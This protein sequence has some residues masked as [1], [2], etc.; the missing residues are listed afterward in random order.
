MLGLFWLVVGGGGFIL[1]GSGFSW[2][3]MCDGWFILVVVG[4][5]RYFLGGG[6]G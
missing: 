5:G 2:V 6:W 1:G 4:G 3:V